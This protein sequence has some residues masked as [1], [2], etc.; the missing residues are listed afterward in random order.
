MLSTKLSLVTGISSLPALGGLRGR[1]SPRGLLESSGKTMQIPRRIRLWVALTV[2]SSF[3][4]SNRWNSTLSTQGRLISWCVLPFKIAAATVCRVPSSWVA[5]S[6]SHVPLRL[7]K[8]MKLWGSWRTPLRLSAVGLFH[9]QT[10]IASPQDWP[11]PFITCL[12]SG[13]AEVEEPISRFLQAA[14]NLDCHR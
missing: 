8:Y 5:V 1:G 6:L 13:R 9:P 14:W 3:T 10:W 7:W 2:S 12:W 4:I 11:L